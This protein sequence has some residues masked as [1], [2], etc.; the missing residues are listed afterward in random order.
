MELIRFGPW[1]R[2]KPFG[3]SGLGLRKS[4]LEVLLWHGDRTAR[5]FAVGALVLPP[6]C[7]RLQVRSDGTRRWALS[8]S[9]LIISGVSIGACVKPAWNRAP[10]SGPG[11]RSVVRHKSRASF[12]GLSGCERGR[13]VATKRRPGAEVL[14]L[15]AFL[16][17]SFL[18]SRSWVRE[19]AQS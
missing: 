19:R 4:S 5:P 6:T 13:S 12:F 11:G 2:G 1:C 18:W 7:G 17:V 10:A 8:G 15:R 9:S 14:R 3:T 16:F